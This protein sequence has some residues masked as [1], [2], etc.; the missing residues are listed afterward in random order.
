MPVAD[1]WKVAELIR[2]VSETV[3]MPR[4]RNLAEGDVRRK[5]PAGDLVTIADHEAEDWLAARLAVLLPG[6]RVIGE[7]GVAADPGQLNLFDGPNPVWVIDPIDGT[8]AFSEGRPSFD[9]M[10]ALV[11]DKQP[12]AGWIYAPVDRDLYVGERGA[13]AFR[14]LDGA[15]AR[16]I[17][18]PPHR[19]LSALGGIISPTAFRSRGYQDPE[20]V[21]N[22]F[23]EFSR[24]TNSG[25]NYARLFRLE[26]DFLINFSTP[27]WDHLPGL[28]IA[29][30]I[31]LAH[32]RLDGRPFDPCDRQGGILVAPDKETWSD[33][34]GILLRPA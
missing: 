32:G 6:S 20:T 34:L 13:G 19:P 3:I 27:P 25:H 9:V 5:S 26:S 21:R 29:D 33:L 17:I 4:W 31:G 23:G 10:V 15:E 14:C 28:A 18:A 12:V 2:D 8:R 16:R 24:H 30:S 22:A 11:Q 7:E 1:V